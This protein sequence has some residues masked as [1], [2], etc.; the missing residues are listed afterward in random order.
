ME[1][2]SGVGG[3]AVKIFTTEDAEQE[4]SITYFS[5][6][7]DYGQM[8]WGMVLTQRQGPGIPLPS[9]STPSPL[10]THHEM[11]FM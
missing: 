3:M 2:S 11:P 4:E 6:L 10:R 7:Q 9:L 1:G 5:E 8:S